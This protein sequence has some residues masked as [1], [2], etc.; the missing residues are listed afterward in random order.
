MLWGVHPMVAL[1][2]RPHSDVALCLSRKTNAIFHQT[3]PAAS[4]VQFNLTLP[5][6]SAP[7][8]RF[9]VFGS[10]LVVSLSVCVVLLMRLLL[11]D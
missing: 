2:R 8:A 3:S 4:I 7:E 11:A 6:Q 5:F 1:R 9:D 10:V